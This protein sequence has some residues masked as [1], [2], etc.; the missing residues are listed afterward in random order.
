[1][2]D[3]RLDP[4]APLPGPPDPWAET[5]MPSLRNGPPWHMTEMIEAEPALAVRILERLAADGSADALA[6]AATDHAGAGQPIAVVGCGTSEHGARAVAALL[7]EAL[8]GQARVRSIQAFEAGVDDAAAQGPALV[9]GVSHEGATWATMRALEVA[10]AG[11]AT[12]ALITVS[13]RSPAGALADVILETGE[14]DQSWCHTV[15]YLSPI[16]AATAVA[17]AVRGTPVDRPAVRAT[18]A[19]G[20]KGAVAAAAEVIARALAGCERIVVIGS[21][22]DRVAARELTLKLEEGTHI[23]AAF[24]DVETLLHG[25]LA[26]MD[27]RTGTALLAGDPIEA[28]A[29]ARRTG[30]A[31]R[32]AREVGSRAAAILT[33]EYAERID[34]SLTPGGRIVVPGTGGRLPP[35]AS[36]LLS[37]AVPLQLL[38]ERIARERGVNPDPIRRDDPRYLRA[39]E[40]SS[41]EG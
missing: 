14:L 13:R 27:E 7:R 3:R 33:G 28:D 20:L 38:T 37:T 29:R 22:T 4:D 5:D 2:D 11:G 35:A 16:V 36:A 25:H 1:M 15:G 21:G 12:T 31:L 30:Q 23:P 6:R 18:L 41:P 26:G 19:A 24:R 10:R 39:A 40:V 9:I 32:A 8:G 34:A 17:A